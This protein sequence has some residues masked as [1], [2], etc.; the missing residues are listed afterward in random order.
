[1][2][3][4]NKEELDS[5][6]KTIIM[7]NDS[8]M[9]TISEPH[10]KIRRS[11][12]SGENLEPIIDKIIKI[13]NRY[14][15]GK[16]KRFVSLKGIIVE[17]HPLF[18][19]HY[20]IILLK[21][22]KMDFDTFRHKLEQLSNKLCSEEFEFDLSDAFLSSKIKNILSKPCYDRFAK[23]SNGHDFLGEYLVKEHAKY[24]L[25]QDRKFCRKKDDLE[26]FV[27]FK[28]FNNGYGT[29]KYSYH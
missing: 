19:P 9:L 12:A 17:E 26:L 10:N 21:P 20:H 23:V 8:L 4:I 13:A 11:V 6:L 2:N 29:R 3:K 18:T 16:H 14:I 7:D 15:Y 28:K 5:W 25:L 22:E 27:N 1:M 24:Y